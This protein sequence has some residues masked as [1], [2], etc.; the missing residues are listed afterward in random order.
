[1]KINEKLKVMLKSM[2]SIK[3]SEVITDKGTLIYDAETLEIGVEVFVTNENGEIE[4]AEDGE[5]VGEEVTIVVVDGKVAEI[6]EKAVEEEVEKSNEEEETI[7]EET[8]LE[9]TI[10]EETIVDPIE[11]EVVEENVEIPSDKLE[12]ILETLTSLNNKILS[13]EGKITEL[14]E[15]LMKVEKEPATNPIEEEEVETLKMSRL[16]YLKK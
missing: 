6:I 14:E 11:E 3:L 4:K 5:Y 2:L 15:R 1:M 13:L 12:E 7:V 8:I 10:V 16:S 9:E